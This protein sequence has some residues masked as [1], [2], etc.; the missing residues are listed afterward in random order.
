MRQ[1]LLRGT[2]RSFV[3]EKDGQRIIQG[4]FH[5]GFRARLMRKD[6]RIARQSARGGTR[7]L[8]ATTLAERLLDELCDSGGAEL[9]W[10]AVG[11]L[12]DEKSI[13]R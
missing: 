1:V 12:V 4:E 6:L 10:S 8:L 7:Q 9:D 11:R 5:P 2:A 13:G 3:L